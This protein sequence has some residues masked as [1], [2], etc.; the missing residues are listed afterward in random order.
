MLVGDKNA[1]TGNID[2]TVLKPF[3]IDDG[4]FIVEVNITNLE[5]VMFSI[6]GVIDSKSL[7][8]MFQTAEKFFNK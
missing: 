2:G 7:P 1:T 3:I 6:R 4:R 8:D 5:N